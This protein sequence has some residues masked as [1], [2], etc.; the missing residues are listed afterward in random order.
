MDMHNQFFSTMRSVN[1]AGV[2]STP[3]PHAT[4]TSADEIIY[5]HG[6]D[7]NKRKLNNTTIEA[8]G[9]DLVVRVLPFES[10]LKVPQNSKISLGWVRNIEGIQIFGASGQQY[11]V[12]GGY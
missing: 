11:N 4:T 10:C 9:S 7:G 2:W 8:L 1:T 12:Y 6:H 3:A 5:F